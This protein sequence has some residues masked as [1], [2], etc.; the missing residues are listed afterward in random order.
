MVRWI[1]ILPII[2]LYFSCG[3]STKIESIEFYPDTSKEFKRI[4]GSY[5]IQNEFGNGSIDFLSDHTYLHKFENDTFS[6]IDEG[7]WETYYDNVWEQTTIMAF[8]W[9][10]GYKAY[11]SV[12]PYE[13]MV[14]NF[15][16]EDSIIYLTN[17]PVD[18][19]PQHDFE[20]D[21]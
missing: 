18:K 19:C 20:R 11:D 1:K 13:D 4:C 3:S 5:K 9:K 15:V 8:D 14:Q 6:L 17:V 12:N 7:I 10:W 16:W 21:E 2:F